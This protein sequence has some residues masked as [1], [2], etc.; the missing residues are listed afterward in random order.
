MTL[1]TS[2]DVN[3]GK[4]TMAWSSGKQDL[5]LG[6]SQTISGHPNRLKWAE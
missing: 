4:K 3:F 6:T 5:M 1:N 2:L